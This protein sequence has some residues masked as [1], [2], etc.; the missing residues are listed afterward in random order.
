MGPMGPG[1]LAFATSL[2]AMFNVVLLFAILSRRLGGIHASDLTA[3]LTKIG[4]ASLV[5]GL[6]LA[7][8]RTLGEW[9]LGLNLVNGLVLGACVLGGLVIFAVAA[10]LLRCTELRS[11]IRLV[12][13]RLAG[14]G[15]SDAR[16][17][18]QREK[19]DP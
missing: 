6:V 9:P 15:S 8:G 10:Y 18:A 5:M 2:A 16:S 11:M 4:A 19:S 3:S 7:Y 17:D 12:Q 13:G 1:G 14:A